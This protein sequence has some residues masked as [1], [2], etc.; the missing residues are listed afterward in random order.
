MVGSHWWFSGID[1]TTTS[2]DR[3]LRVCLHVGEYRSLSINANC[4]GDTILSRHCLHSLSGLYLSTMEA[5]IVSMEPS[6]SE[7]GPIPSIWS[8]SC[9]RDHSHTSMG[10]PEY[11]KCDGVDLMATRGTA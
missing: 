2:Y 8:A 5:H 11:L 7:H 1:N 9:P 4:N 3:P 6:P 10:Q